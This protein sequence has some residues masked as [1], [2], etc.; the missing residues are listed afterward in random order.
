MILFIY[1]INQANSYERLKGIPNDDVPYRPINVQVNTLEKD[2][3]TKDLIAIADQVASDFKL[4]GVRV[5]NYFR[6]VKFASLSRQ[7]FNRVDFNYEDKGYR[8]VTVAGTVIKITKAN[9]VYTVKCRKVYVN[10][11]VI[12]SSYIAGAYEYTSDFLG[13]LSQGSHMQFMTKPW[14]PLPASSIAFIYNELYKRIEGPLNW[15]KTN[16]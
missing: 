4:E 1:L 3:S 8:V 9:D 2:Y 6:L 10:S 5:H 12:D 15:Y 11:N 16:I 14:S 13:Y 7:L